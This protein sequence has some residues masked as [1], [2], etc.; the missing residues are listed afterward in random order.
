V[1]FEADAQPAFDFDRTAGY[2]RWRNSV[3]NLQE[4]QLALRNEFIPSNAYTD[5]Q[6]NSLFDPVQLQ[7]PASV[8]F[9]FSPFFCTLL[10]SMEENVT[11]GSC[12]TS[13]ASFPC[14]VDCTELR[15]FSD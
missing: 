7:F 4:E 5:W 15:S 8:R 13:S 3:I 2:L 9:H 12:S 6:M 10:T 11:S 1:H 14:I